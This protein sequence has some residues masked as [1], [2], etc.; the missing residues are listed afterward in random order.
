MKYIIYAAVA[1][2]VVWAVVYLVCHVRRQLKGDCGSC[3]GGCSGDCSC[4]GKKKD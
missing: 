3:G 1:A 2:L 4:C